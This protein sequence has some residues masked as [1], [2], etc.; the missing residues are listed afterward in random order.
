MSEHRF[1]LKAEW[2]GGLDGTGHIRAGNL[3]SGIS[4]PSQLDG[5]GIGTNPEEMLLGAAATC[6]LITL[7]MLLKRLGIASI[8]LN[9]EIFVHSSPAM[10]VD[11]IIH[12][13]RICIPA[14][15]SQEITDKISK[16]AY[17]AEQTCMISK[18]LKG[19]VEVIVEPDIL[20]LKE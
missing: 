19:N 9:S 1:E 14:H 5:P 20:L 12:R 18:A 4:V 17:R 13:P 2:S 16:A 6:Y 11:K 15:T 7:S 3:V 10:K 8:E